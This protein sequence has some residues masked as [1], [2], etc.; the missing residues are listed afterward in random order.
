[1]AVDYICPV[2]VLKTK[3]PF[4]LVTLYSLVWVSLR[5]TFLVMKKRIVILAK[6]GTQ[7]N[8]DFAGLQLFCKEID[9]T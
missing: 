2:L 9:M 5:N 3:T 4:N 1:M 8:I 6:Q 7:S